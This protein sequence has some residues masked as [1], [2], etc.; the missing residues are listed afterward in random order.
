MAINI[1][2]IISFIL[3]F[4]IMIKKH[5]KIPTIGLAILAF[6]NVF[7]LITFDESIKCFASESIAIYFGISIITE[8]LIKNGFIDYIA[9]LIFSKTK[10]FI[11]FFLI[12]IP[13]VSFLSIVISLK[14]TILFFLNLIFSI[15]RNSKGKI[16]KK[17]GILFTMA[18]GCASSSIV[19]FSTKLLLANEILLEFGVNTIS[20][21]YFLPFSIM[22]LIILIVYILIR[23]ETFF[24]K[25]L[26][27]VPPP[28]QPKENKKN[29]IIASIVLLSC[30]IL[31][32]FTNI[33]VGL[34]CV[35]G[36]LICIITNCIGEKEAVQSVNWW[37]IL[38]LGSIKA[39]CKVLN[40]SFIFDSL[41]NYLQIFINENTPILL[42]IIVISIVSGII[43][44]LIDNKLAI[45]T[46]LPICLI[47]SKN[48]GIDP[49]VLVSSIV[50]G[51]NFSILS[52]IDTTNNIILEE[53]DLKMKDLYKVAFPYVITIYVSSILL[54]YFNSIFKFM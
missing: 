38:Y 47:I 48:I 54:I 10:K 6:F 43:C 2:K 24:A 39:I 11:V 20:N 26:E 7:G 27:I 14:I 28:K 36:A 51:A 30:I 8:V 31:P 19:I 29:N 50:I 15:E 18:E 44:C 37:I 23:R 33:N 4:F 41:G 5:Y 49:I 22:N 16:S 12:I 35:V 46:L 13:I 34:I 9:N 25:K 32:I 42:V 17:T 53:C 52:P 1:V 40:N 21:F 3:L 45:S